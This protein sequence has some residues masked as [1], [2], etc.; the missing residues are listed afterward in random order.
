[1]PS[2]AP[3]PRIIRGS[4]VGRLSITNPGRNR[5]STAGTPTEFERELSI[6][7]NSPN[8][9]LVEYNGDLNKQV[10]LA[11]GRLDAQGTYTARAMFSSATGG[12][13]NDETL[14]ASSGKNNSVEVT[15]QG[16]QSSG[17]QY[18]LSG[19][20]HPWSSDDQA[21]YERLVA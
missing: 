1:Q 16:R 21:Q 14:T 12:A 9:S 2:V 4:Y 20:L 6:D 3:V 13:R 11:D 17:E 10:P 5:R 8:G 7:P 15:F 18:T 19:A